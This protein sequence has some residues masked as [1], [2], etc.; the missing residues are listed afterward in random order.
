MSTTKIC[1]NPIC[2]DPV[3]ACYGEEERYCS[4]WCA[5]NHRLTQI[6][7]GK[8]GR[9]KGLEAHA[10]GHITDAQFEKLRQTWG[11]SENEEG[12]DP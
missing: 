11:P 12:I 7:V 5:R 2:D 1:Q 4:L 8:Y 9:K 6:L 3:P 10:Q